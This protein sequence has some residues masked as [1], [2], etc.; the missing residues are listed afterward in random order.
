MNV[1]FDAVYTRWTAVMGA[2]TLYNTE[3]DDEASFPYSTMTIVGDIAD[4]TFTE[5]FEDVLIQFNLFSETPACTEVGATFEALKTAFDKHAL[6]ITGYTTISLERG[7]A[8]LVR[9]DNKWQYIVQYRIL[10]QKD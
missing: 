6:T 1:L 5:D 10:I 8:N 3:A 7:V 4:W 9:V 2:R